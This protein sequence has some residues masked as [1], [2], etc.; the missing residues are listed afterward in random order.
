MEGMEFTYR[1]E[2]RDWSPWFAS[3]PWI[4][5]DPAALPE[6]DL[7]SVRVEGDDRSLD[8]SGD[9]YTCT[10]PRE[11]NVLAEAEIPRAPLWVAPSSTWTE[12]ADM[13]LAGAD[14]VLSGVIPPDIRGA[15]IEAAAAGA[16]PFMAAERAR[17]LLTESF[18]VADHPPGWQ[19]FRVSGLQDILDRRTATPLEMAVLMAVI[20]RELGLEAEI[21][22][23]SSRDPVLPVP[24]GWDRFLVRLTGDSGR[25]LVTEP[26][27]RLV[28]SGYVHAPDTLY[29]L[30]RRE[31]RVLTRPPG[32]PMENM[33]RER[34]TI[35]PVN[36]VF[37][38][39]L[40]CRGYYDMVL[41]RKLAGLGEDE[42]PAALSAWIWRGGV[43]LVPDSVSVS[44]FY[45]LSEP[46]TLLASGVVDC[47]SPG[48]GYFTRTPSIPWEVPPGTGTDMVRSW[49]LPG[50]A[51]SPEIDGLG[52]ERNGYGTVFTD[53]AGAAAPFLVMLEPGR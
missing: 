49:S 37:T 45:D 25:T 33:C 41:R 38:L 47:S 8:H 10:V 2:T 5:F 52:T 3:G 51:I 6:I 21:L 35:D 11:G 48:T 22:P 4:L 16:D 9:G 27:A 14:S 7:V 43:V 23:V 24:A 15:V 17:T 29:L 32:G 1:L 34:W 44:D 53:S 12:L 13:L 26:S 50:S 36:G 19:V 42:L 18:I 40:D 28:Q 39:E 46:A 31:G 20:G 30:S